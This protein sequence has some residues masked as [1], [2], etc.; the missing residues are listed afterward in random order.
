MHMQTCCCCGFR[1]LATNSLPINTF[2]TCCSL[3]QVM[4]ATTHTT[5]KLLTCLPPNIC[6]TQLLPVQVWKNKYNNNTTKKRTTR[7]VNCGLWAPRQTC[8]YRYAIIHMSYIDIHI[9]DNTCITTCIYYIYGYDDTV[10]AS[11][12]M[13]LSS[14]PSGRD[15]RRRQYNILI[16]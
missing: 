7:R 1:N 4:D 6:A 16:Y 11:A 5:N 10:C 14:S 3:F 13:L 2:P 8:C 9:Y 12:N 15:L